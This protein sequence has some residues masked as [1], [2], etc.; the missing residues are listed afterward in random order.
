MLVHNFFCRNYSRRCVSLQNKITGRCK[1]LLQTQ[2]LAHT[3][4]SFIF[5]QNFEPNTNSETEGSNPN[6]GNIFTIAF[7]N[8][9]CLYISWAQILGDVS[10][11][12][13][14][15]S[16]AKIKSDKFESGLFF[17]KFDTI[18]KNFLNIKLFHGGSL[19]I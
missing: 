11:I 6:D 9:Y 14:I 13:Y 18:F 19:E 3:F 2:P 15:M 4:L 1:Y 17:S 7:V 10:F 8:M 12:H 5:G 16:R